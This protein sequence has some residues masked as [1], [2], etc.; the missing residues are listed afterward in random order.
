[1]PNFSIER[2]YRRAERRNNSLRVFDS[3]GNLPPAFFNSFVE[4]RVS[5]KPIAVVE[6][7]RSK[8]E[9]E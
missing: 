5:G 3:L 8:D 7:T 1:M 2:R 6:D 4:L 9:K